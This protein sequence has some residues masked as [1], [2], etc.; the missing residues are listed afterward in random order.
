MGPPDPMYL[1]SSDPDD[2]IEGNNIKAGDMVIPMWGVPIGIRRSS[3]NPEQ[4]DIDRSNTKP[5]MGFG[6][7]PHFCAGAELARSRGK[8]C[9]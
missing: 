1:S 7:G 5:H 6:F 8:N 4:F 2:T 3:L 9:L